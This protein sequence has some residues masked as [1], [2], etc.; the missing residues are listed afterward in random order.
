MAKVRVLIPATDPLLLLPCR[1][2]TGLG[3]PLA[4][5][6]QPIQ[7]NFFRA[8]HS[9]QATDEIHFVRFLRLYRADGGADVSIKLPLA[10]ALSCSPA[11]DIYH[12]LQSR[13]QGSG[14]YTL[15]PAPTRS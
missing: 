12:A 2:R 11:R 15:P 4:L 10:H 5:L 1:Q 9:L 8:D 14:S 3:E 6:R 7:G 13:A